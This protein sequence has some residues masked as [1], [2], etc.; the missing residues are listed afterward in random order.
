MKLSL[1]VNDIFRQE[2]NHLG[3]MRLQQVVD[4]VMKNND[5]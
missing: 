4:L 3:P 2:R 5:A 1:A